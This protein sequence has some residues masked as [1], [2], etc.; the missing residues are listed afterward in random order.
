MPTLTSP[1][2][3]LSRLFRDRLW[4][5]LLKPSF[6]RLGHHKSIMEKQRASL[7]VIWILKQNFGILEEKSISVNEDDFTKAG[8]KDSEWLPSPAFQL[9]APIVDHLAEVAGYNAWK[10]LQLRSEILSKVAVSEVH[11]LDRQFAAKFA[12]YVD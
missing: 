4:Q 8:Q 10:G 5:R 1:E 9:P 11:N 12:E 2:P 6:L 3:T 7:G